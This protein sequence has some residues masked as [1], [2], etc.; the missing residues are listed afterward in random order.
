MNSDLANRLPVGLSFPGALVAW[1][2]SL[3]SGHLYPRA[4]PKSIS[5]SSEMFILGL[6]SHVARK[7]VNAPHEARKDCER[8][9]TV[10]VEDDSHQFVSLRINREMVVDD[11]VV[12]I[13]HREYD[14]YGEEKT[15]Q[16]GPTL[17]SKY[18]NSC[19]S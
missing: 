11:T 5:V 19:S 10:Q 9:K 17:L 6:K 14:V 4:P 1:R 3:T 15:I 2:R 18:I 13:S 7:M 16:Y 12:G 8:H